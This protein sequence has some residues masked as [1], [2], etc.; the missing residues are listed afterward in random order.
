MA[1]MEE[2]RGADHL[3][4]SHLLSALY[5]RVVKLYGI[6]GQGPLRSRAD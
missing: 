1:F 6:L 5:F 4:A 2:C 3:V